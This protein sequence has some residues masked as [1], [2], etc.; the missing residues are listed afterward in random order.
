MKTIIPVI[1]NC[2]CGKKVKNHHFY[3]DECYSKKNKSENAIL[4]KQRV[5]ADIMADRRRRNVRIPEYVK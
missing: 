1:E 4:N 3:C 5:K 2:K